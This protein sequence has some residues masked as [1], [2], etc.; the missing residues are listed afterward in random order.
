MREFNVKYTPEEFLELADRLKPRLYSIAS[1]HDAHPG[2]VELTVGIVRFNYHDRQRG[3]LCTQYMADEVV[4]NET[5][6]GV[7]MSPT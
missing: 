4:V 1:S 2:F 7:F 3:G 5:D 6:V